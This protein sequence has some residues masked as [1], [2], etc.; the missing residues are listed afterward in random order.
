MKR[1]LF[2]L[3]AL[4]AIYCSYTRMT[5]NNFYYND[6]HEEIKDTITALSLSNFRKSYMVYGY[7]AGDISEPGPYLVA[8]YTTEYGKQELVDSY[9]MGTPGFYSLSLPQGSFY[10]YVFRDINRNFIFSDNECVGRFEGNS[11]TITFATV[12]TLASSVRRYDIKINEDVIKINLSLD[13]KFE[14]KPQL[15]VSTVFPMG[16][17]RDIGDEIFDKKYG[18]MGL[19]NPE[20]FRDQIELNFYALQEYSPFKRPILFIHGRRGTPAIFKKLIAGLDQSKFQPW[21]FYYP[22]GAAAN[23]TVD[24]LYEIFF[25]GRFI[26]ASRKEMIIL[27]EG[28][29]ALILKGVINRTLAENKPNQIKALITIGAPFNGEV[30]DSSEDM[31]AKGNDVFLNDLTVSSRFVKNLNSVK[32]EKNFDHFLFFTYAEANRDSAVIKM[33]NVD[34]LKSQLQYKSQF[35]STAIFGFNETAKS[36]LESDTLA[37]KLKEILTKY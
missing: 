35:S 9:Q 33:Q 13:I 20:E 29:G 12:D 17:L 32:I 34:K 31:T 24:I 2:S 18:I 26:K 4:F 10:L 30:I 1:F 28:T 14:T 7:L 16:T 15:T 37:I 22:S 21:F 3:L 25:S 27:T 8:A 5:V 23:E 6:Q 19:Y 36:I 11:Q